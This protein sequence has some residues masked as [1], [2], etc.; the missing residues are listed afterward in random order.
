MALINTGASLPSFMWAVVRLLLASGGAVDEESA[1][2]VLTPLSLPAGAGNDEYDVAVKTLDELGFVTVTGGTAELT[3]LARAL[4]V[5]DVAGFNAQLRTAVFDPA[6]NE[7]LATSPDLGGPK[8][9]VRALCW[10]L[11]QNVNT[12]VGWTEIEQLQRDAFPPPLPLPFAD[13]SSRWNRFVYWGPA[14]GLAAPPL[15]PEATAARLVPDCTVAV[16]ETVLSLWK[17]GQSVRPREAT[18]SL[19]AELPVLPGGRYSRS[20][21]LAAPDDA[22]SPTLSNALLTG[23]Q[24]GWITLDQKSDAADVIF[25]LDADGTRVPVSNVKING[26]E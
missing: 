2:L 10:F 23:H 11:T 26:G 8:D 21:A 4:P 1:R 7:D 19:L 22:V 16:R 25:L 18:V 9:L 17:E 14:L 13:N 5:D 12:P 24:A 20:L 15:R 6:R 3:A